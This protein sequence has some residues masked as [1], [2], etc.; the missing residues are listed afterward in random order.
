MTYLEALDYIHSFQRFGKKPGLE[1]MRALM[2]LLGNPQE[3]LHVVHVAG[4]NGKGSTCAMTAGI[5]RAAGYRTGLSVSPYILN[6]RERIQIDGELIPEQAL[7]E[8]TA[9][10]RPLADR[11][12]DLTEFELVTAIAFDWFARQDCEV[13]VLEVGLGGRF[14]ATNVITRPLVAAITPIGLDH[15]AV[16]GNT[17]EQIAFEKCGILKP[18]VPVV[19]SPGQP[20]DALGVIFEEAAGKGCEI[21]Q[22]RLGAVEELEM[23][24]EGSSFAYDMFHLQ[25]PLA[26]RHQ[27]ANALAAV[28]LAVLAQAE[29]G[30]RRAAKVPCLSCEMVEE[31]IGSVHFPARM[32]LLRREPLTIL[33]GAHNPA[34]AR[35]LAD[36]LSMLKGRP[37]TAVMGILA[38]KDSGGVLELLV[39]YF[40][41]LICVTPQNPRA[42]DAH[43]LASR[44]GQLGLSAS[45]AHSAQ[46]AWE[47][48]EAVARL[49]DGAVVICGSL[50]LAAELRRIILGGEVQS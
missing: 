14:D 43:E 46:E 16:L 2:E 38:D 12:E 11:V 22:P 48:A 27:V 36:S 40:R 6:F 32:E 33:D 31:G 1:R 21:I 4:T 9:R 37:V 30:R 49:E 26:G 34:G 25:V 18:G 39:P 50:Y 5:L 8:E 35:S 13:V 41:R 15:T 44:A 42:L 47:L 24:L 45:A 7:A 19:V 10:I 20:D 23:G 3:R 17:I 29:L 28:E